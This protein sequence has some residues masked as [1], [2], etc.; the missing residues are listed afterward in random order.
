MLL[1]IKCSILDPHLIFHVSVEAAQSTDIL[2]KIVKNSDSFA[3]YICEFSA[4]LDI[5]TAFSIE[6]RAVF[7]ALPN[8]Y[9]KAFFV[10]MCTTDG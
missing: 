9:D 10:K 4:S 6:Y 5:T 8:I 7:R 3:E 2:V 1:K